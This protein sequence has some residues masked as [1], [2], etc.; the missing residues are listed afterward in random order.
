MQSLKTCSA[1]PFRL[2]QVISLILKK[3]I[4]LQGLGLGRDDFHQS[5][6]PFWFGALPIENVTFVKIMLTLF[7]DS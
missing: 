1:V 5:M 6:N 2:N 7:L 4:W 3:S